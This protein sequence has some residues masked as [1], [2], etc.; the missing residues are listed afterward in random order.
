[1]PN[2][3]VDLPLADYSS[4]T[5]EDKEAWVQQWLKE[6]AGR[7]FALDSRSP[8]F[9]IQLLQLAADE[10]IAVITMHHIVLDGWSISVFVMEL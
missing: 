3:S 9:R 1:M 10:V 6:E 7:P 4:K 5:D 2:I 8:L